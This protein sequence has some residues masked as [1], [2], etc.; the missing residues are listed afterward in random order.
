MPKELN[1]FIVQGLLRG[2]AKKDK[3]G[4]WGIAPHN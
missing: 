2:K 1:A 4:F 3:T